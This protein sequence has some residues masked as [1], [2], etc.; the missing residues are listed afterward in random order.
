[1]GIAYAHAPLCERNHA[2]EYRTE[3]VTMWFDRRL[4]LRPSPIQGIGTF[5]TETIQPGE[6]L[7]YVTGGVVFTTDDWQLGRISLLGDL[8]NQETL[9]DNLFLATPKVFHYYINH[10][11]APNAIDQSQH[12]TATQYVA[13]RAI[14]AQEEVTT[15]YGLYGAANIAVCGCHSRQCRGQITANDWQLPAFQQ[16]YRG[17]LPWRIAQRIQQGERSGEPQDHTRDP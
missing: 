16:R 2:V 15:D 9:A 14:A 6:M 11:C 4:V 17:A 13:W 1:M 3:P 8:Y 12:P 10:S 5:A 7:I